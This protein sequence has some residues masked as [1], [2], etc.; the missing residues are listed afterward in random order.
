MGKVLAILCSD[1]HLSHNAPVARSAEPDWY[2]AMKRPLD[3]IADLAKA[4]GRMS[5]G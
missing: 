1:I 3:E 4:N 2:I 5:S